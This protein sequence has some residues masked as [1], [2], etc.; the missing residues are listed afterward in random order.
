MNKNLLSTACTIIVSAGIYSSALNAATVN[1][2]NAS[3]NVQAPL[4][5]SQTTPM[6]FADVT[7]D[8]DAGT[9]VILDTANGASSPDG[10]KATGTPASG[11][12]AVSGA[13]N[14]SYIIDFSANTAVTLT[15]AGD[16]MTLDTFT[17]SESGVGTLSTGS[18][19]F[20]VGATLHLNAGQAVGGYV[21]TYVVDIS[22]Q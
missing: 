16:P 14:L 7:G 22:Y 2:A 9:T 8:A 17:D 1:N 12:F 20:T 13:G 6:N 15:G 4:S 18:D 19:S 21:G 3:A 5:I 11:A 10:A